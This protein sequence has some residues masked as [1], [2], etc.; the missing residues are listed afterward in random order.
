MQ[1]RLWEMILL[2]FNDDLELKTSSKDDRED[3]KL[4][5]KLEDLRIFRFKGGAVE[6]LNDTAWAAAEYHVYLSRE[7][8]WSRYILH[9]RHA[10]WVIVGGVLHGGMSTV[11]AF[12]FMTGGGFTLNDYV[13]YSPMTITLTIEGNWPMLAMLHRQHPRLPI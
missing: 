8:V 5:R 13:D 2:M 11:L 4:G 10:A 6:I 1:E 7:G 12:R 9:V 3:Q